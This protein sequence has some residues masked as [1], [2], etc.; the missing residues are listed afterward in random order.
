[1]HT[2]ASMKNAVMRAIRSVGRFSRSGGLVPRSS[3]SR[4][5]QANGV[6]VED[7]SFD[8]LMR[9]SHDVGNSDPRKEGDKRTGNTYS[10][11]YARSLL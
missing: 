5:H 10:M 1:M 4:P 7:A 3:R 11:R 9:R 6:T 2:I 8:L